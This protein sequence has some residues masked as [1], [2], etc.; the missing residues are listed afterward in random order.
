MFITGLTQNELFETM[1][2]LI[3][4]A[5]AKND[6]SNL[7]GRAIAIGA[8]RINASACRYL[9]ST[10]VEIGC[11]LFI[12]NVYNRAEAKATTANLNAI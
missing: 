1:R 2:H 10:P 8:I 12:A 11:F 7:T 5:S 3:K 4:R 6:N 9:V